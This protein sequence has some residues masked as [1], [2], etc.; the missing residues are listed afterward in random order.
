M[1]VQKYQ[2]INIIKNKQIISVQVAGIVQV[3]GVF[4]VAGVRIN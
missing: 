1:V 4:Q 2:S 3:A